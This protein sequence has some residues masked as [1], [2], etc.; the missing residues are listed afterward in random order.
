MTI[1]QNT[2]TEGYKTK[3]PQ[4]L[5][6]KILGLSH[7]ER[8][9][10]KRGRRGCSCFGINLT[11]V[12][13]QCVNLA[14]AHHAKS[15]GIYPIPGTDTVYVEFYNWPNMGQCNFNEPVKRT[16]N[17][18]W[19]LRPIPEYMAPSDPMAMKDDSRGFDMEA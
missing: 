14:A 16:K 2:Y 4:S 6:A 3:G 11:D 10:R 12:A 7:S 18:W 5:F 1:A 19:D 9:A 17:Y 15:W 8:R 13:R